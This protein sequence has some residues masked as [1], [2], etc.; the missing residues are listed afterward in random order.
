[1]IVSLLGTFFDITS[2]SVGSMLSYTKD[3][4]SDAQLL[5]LA[6]IGVLLG[7]LVI[8]AIVSAIRK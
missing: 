5:I 8:E 3:I 1:M 4:F 7:L 2:E 6:I